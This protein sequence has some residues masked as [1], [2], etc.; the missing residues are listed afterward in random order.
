MAIRIRYKQV[1]ARPYARLEELRSFVRACD[2]RAQRTVYG[3][4]VLSFTCLL[5]VGEATPIRRG[6]SRSR[7]VEFHTIKSDQQLVGKEA[8]E[9]RQGMAT[10]VGP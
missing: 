9:L 8:G 7:G 10:M 6:G 2:G 1:V 5:R 3:L 4:A